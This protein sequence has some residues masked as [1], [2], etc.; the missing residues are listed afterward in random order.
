MN[1]TILDLNLF[2]LVRVAIMEAPLKR[3]TF[4]AFTF[5]NVFIIVTGTR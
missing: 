1:N 4:L 5:V 3:A 2:S